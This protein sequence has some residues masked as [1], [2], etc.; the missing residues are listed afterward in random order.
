MHPDLI[1][2]CSSQGPISTIKWQPHLHCQHRR[3]FTIFTCV[4]ITTSYTI[5]GSTPAVR[6]MHVVLSEISSN[7]HR[8]HAKKHRTVCVNTVDNTMY[9][10]TTHTDLTTWKLKNTLHPTVYNSDTTPLNASLLMDFPM[11]KI[12]TQSGCQHFIWYTKYWTHT[13]ALYT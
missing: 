7:K 10:R 4:S 9:Q 12:Y 6:T 8:K 2:I 11:I 1:Y 5:R 13:Y 3:L